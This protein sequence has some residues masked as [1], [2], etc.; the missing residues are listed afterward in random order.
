MDLKN[1][2]EY[3]QQVFQSIP[4]ED[5]PKYRPHTEPIPLYGPDY[6]TWTLRDL[7]HSGMLNLNYQ[8]T[9]FV[10]IM[11]SWNSGYL[12]DHLQD[13]LSDDSLLKIVLSWQRIATKTPAELQLF[14]KFPLNLKIN[15]QGYIS[16][17]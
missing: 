13:E 2:L 17:E 10:D 7:L 8:G 14:P 9:Q 11:Q 5:F 12:E 16:H 6:S 4:I 15:K 3:E 1:A